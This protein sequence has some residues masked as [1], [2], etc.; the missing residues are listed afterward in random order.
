MQ[1]HNHGVGPTVLVVNHRKQGAGADLGIGSS[2]G[3]LDIHGQCGKLQ[4][5]AAI[6]AQS[7]S[8]LDLRKRIASGPAEVKEKH[9]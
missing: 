2:P 1:V 9:D 8:G 5:R 7:S 6:F 4:F 3:R